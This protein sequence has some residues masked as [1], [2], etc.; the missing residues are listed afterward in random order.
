MSGEKCSSH[1][2]IVFFLR[3]KR[4]TATR[5]S[6]TRKTDKAG[7][8]GTFFRRHALRAVRFR[9]AGDLLGLPS[10]AWRARLIPC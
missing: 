4:D 5:K 7:Q 3:T 2:R 9:F 10:R 6:G 8:S 1:V